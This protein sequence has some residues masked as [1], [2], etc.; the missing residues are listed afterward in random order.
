LKPSLAIKGNLQA[1]KSGG[2]VQ[3]FLIVVQFS[4]AVIFIFCTLVINQQ[5]KYMKM[6]DLGFAKDNVLV[7]D[8]N[9]G[10]KDPAKAYQSI[11]AIIQQLKSFPEVQNITASRSVP[12]NYPNWYNVYVTG[13]PTPI[14]LRLRHVSNT[15]ESYFATYDIDFLAG[16]PFFSEKA[17]THQNAVVINNSVAAAYGWKP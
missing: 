14:E 11:D 15:D 6:A 1:S 8:M 13:T 12:G 4:L 3:R 9:M 5:M 2:F 17:L 7:V 10:Y 16:E